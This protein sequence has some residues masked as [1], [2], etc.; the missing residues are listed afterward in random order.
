[1]ATGGHLC[2]MSHRDDVDDVYLFLVHRRLCE[3][4]GLRS[5]C[6]SYSAGQEGGLG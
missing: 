4:V 1:M 2:L 3:M 5:V 6:A